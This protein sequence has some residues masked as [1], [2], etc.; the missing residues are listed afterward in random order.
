[1]PRAITGED[2]MNAR[3]RRCGVI[4]LSTFIFLMGVARGQNTAVTGLRLDHMDGSMSVMSDHL[5]RG[6]VYMAFWATWCVPCVQELRAL[7][8]IMR[9]HP[10]AR[11]SVLAVN[12]DASKGM[13]KV[14]AF[15]AAQ[16]WVSHR[17]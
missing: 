10:D 11:F 3:V 4:L 16:R 15:A 5:A 7:D 14:K 6:P 1:V 2:H 9:R 13:G 12:Q 17:A 8:R